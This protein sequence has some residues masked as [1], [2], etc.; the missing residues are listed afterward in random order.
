M[1]KTVAAGSAVAMGVIG[2]A[3]PLMAGPA[4]AAS[5]QPCDV[6]S[7]MAWSDS[8]DNWFQ[9][10]IPQYGLGKVEFTIS[11]DTDFPADFKDLTDP[12]VTVTSTADVADIN[13]YYGET[14]TSPFTDLSRIDDGTDPKLQRYQ[15]SQVAPLSLEGNPGGVFRVS[16]AT[17]MSPANLP[18]A[19][20]P[21]SYA[22]AYAVTFE[23]LDVTFTQTVNGAQ[24]VYHIVMSPETL[25][26][27]GTMEPGGWNSGAPLCMAQ[28][29]FMTGGLTAS[30]EGWTEA[31][32]DSIERLNMYPSLTGDYFVG[33]Y[34]RAVPTP[35]SPALPA[36]GLELV[37]PLAVAGGL[38]LA[39]LSVLAIRRR[40][41]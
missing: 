12:S 39:G 18:E 8:V 17:A 40:R 31:S 22:D 37:A 33:N 4:Q 25:Y 15:A 23:P 24:W 14:L 2:A 20:G 9:S 3:M 32:S 21:F 41:A 7:D 27:G 34:P 6:Y 13:A 35:D 29:T 10:C 30:D 36:T 11:S 28:G 26:I 38:L 16:S 19:C 1:K 5:A